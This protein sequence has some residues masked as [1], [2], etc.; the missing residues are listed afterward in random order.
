MARPGAD[1]SKIVEPLGG[2]FSIYKA[3]GRAQKSILFDIRMAIPA[4][5]LGPFV[6]KIV[7]QLFTLK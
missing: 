5:F 2:L 6:W 3:G 4:C 7:F 1:S